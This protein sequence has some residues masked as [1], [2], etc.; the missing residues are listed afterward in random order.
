MLPLHA[1]VLAASF[2]Q[3]GPKTTPSGLFGNISFRGGY[4]VGKNFQGTNGT[5]RLEGPQFGIDIPILKLPVS[6]TEFRLSPTIVLGGGARKGNDNDGTIYRVL[7]T[8]KSRIPLSNAYG[9]F[10]AGYATS[11]TRGTTKFD[12]KPAWVTQFGIG[13]NL[14]T[15]GNIAGFKAFVEASYHLGTKQYQ[16]FTLEVGIRF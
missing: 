16:G 7:A 13:M 4:F 2:G 1:L 10:G 6:G 15:S 5:V 8:A 9:L 3:I 12:T 14:G 11:K